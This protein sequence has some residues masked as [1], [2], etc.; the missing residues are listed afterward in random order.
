MRWSVVSPLKVALLDDHALIRDALT[1]RLSS[2]SDIKV[3]GVFAQGN[4]LLQ[5]L[6]E[7][8]IHLLI[9]DYQLSDGELDGL[10]LI[11][12]LRGHYPDLRIL[13]LSSMERPATVNMAIRA[14]AN[15]FFGKSQDAEHLVRA[16]RTVAL[17]RLYLSPAMASELDSTPETSA[18]SADDGDS[19]TEQLVNYPALSPKEREVLRCCLEGMSVS[20][21]AIKFLRSRKTISGQKQAALRKLNVRTDTELFKLH[22]H[23]KDI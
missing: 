16:I 23:L 18:V 2:E 3:V 17:D 9:L 5:A 21:I 14:G 1:I 12:L 19:G 15:G 4:Q 6:R 20:Q 8:E 7:E 11:Q 22:L 10:R 13:V